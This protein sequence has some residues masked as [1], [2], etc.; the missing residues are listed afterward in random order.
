MAL[1]TEHRG[2]CVGTILMLAQSRVTKIGYGS[3]TP[4]SAQ[5]KRN[6][7]RWQT[8]YSARPLGSS[9]T[10]AMR[11]YFHAVGRSRCRNCASDAT[12][13]TR[14]EGKFRTARTECDFR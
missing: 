14:G 8:S 1:I 3:P 7:S 9:V 11:S 5:A 10:L 4:S 12:I 6:A 2:S 13:C